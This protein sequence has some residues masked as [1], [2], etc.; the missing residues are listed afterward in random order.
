MTQNSSLSWALLKLMTDVNSSKRKLWK[1]TRYCQ[2]VLKKKNINAR[3]HQTPQQQ[4]FVSSKQFRHF[5]Q[6][7]NKLICRRTMWSDGLLRSP[8][9]CLGD[10]ERF[11]SAANAAAAAALET[12]ARL[13]CT[14]SRGTAYGT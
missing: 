12:G 7:G 5:P 6:A 10:A 13:S 2:F 4:I 14:C 11:H 9:S 1:I 8:G 3:K